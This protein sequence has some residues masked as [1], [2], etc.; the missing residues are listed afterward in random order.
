MEILV[1]PLTMIT[2]MWNCFPSLGV[3]NYMTHV[4]GICVGMWI[5]YRLHAQ[6]VVPGF[7]EWLIR[8]REPRKLLVGNVVNEVFETLA[9]TW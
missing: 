1:L 4:S 3:V 7:V 9:D 6:D 8:E 2:R 5:Y